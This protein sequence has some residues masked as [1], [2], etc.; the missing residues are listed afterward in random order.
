[1]HKLRDDDG[2]RCPFLRSC[3][4]RVHKGFWNSAGQI[5]ADAGGLISDNKDKQ[6]Y[7]IGHSLGGSIAQLLMMRVYDEMTPKLYPYV[8]AYGAPKVANNWGNQGIYRRAYIR[9]WFIAEDPVP[10]LPVGILNNTGII[11]S[12]FGTNDLNAT[13]GKRWVNGRDLPI[14]SI[15]SHEKYVERIEALQAIQDSDTGNG[16][17]GFNTLRLAEE[18]IEPPQTSVG[19]EPLPQVTKN[20]FDLSQTNDPQIEEILAG[21]IKCFSEEGDPTNALYC[22]ENS[23][24]EP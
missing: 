21:Q 2:V 13:T 6:I 9:K 24:T 23:S 19:L 18:A 11:H 4:M 12:F 7:F 5:I 20:N 10:R 8:F 17:S 22:F 15:S 14:P 16:G 3:A 1:M